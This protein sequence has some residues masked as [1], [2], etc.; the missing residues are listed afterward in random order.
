MLECP[1]C[2]IKYGRKLQQCPNCGAAAINH[3]TTQAKPTAL[4]YHQ[5]LQASWRQP[6]QTPWRW[7]NPQFGWVT[8]AILLLVNTATISLL[9]AGWSEQVGAVAGVTGT[10]VILRQPVALW[11]LELRLF[12]IQLGGLLVLIGTGYL[13]KRYLLKQKNLRFDRYLTEISAYGSFVLLLTMA[14]LLVTFVAGL[15]ALWLVVILLVLSYLW[16]NMAIVVSLIRQPMAGFDQFY[17]VILF[18]IIVHLLLLVMSSQ[19]VMMGLA[20]LF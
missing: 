5:F 2:H 1:Q 3:E 7:V 10:Q 13:L 17:T 15:M 20:N 4:K 18:E 6:L 9:M 8:F 12:L 11:P 14:A 19:V 16:V